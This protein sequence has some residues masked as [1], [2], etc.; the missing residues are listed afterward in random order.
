MSHMLYTLQILSR[1]EYATVL[2]RHVQ[3]LAM[4]WRRGELHCRAYASAALI[5]ILPCF[6]TQRTVKYAIDAT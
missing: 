5:S 6:K 3:L 1:W 2:L 4:Q